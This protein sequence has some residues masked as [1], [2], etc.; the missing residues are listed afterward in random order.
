MKARNVERARYL[1]DALRELPA[2]EKASRA[3]KVDPVLGD[4][5]ACCVEFGDYCDDGGS[6]SAWIE[7]P[8][9]MGATLLPLIEKMLRDELARLGVE[10][11]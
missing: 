8:P 9:A 4:R 10:G 7:I 5:R 11:A 3:T 1:L 2:M 6:P